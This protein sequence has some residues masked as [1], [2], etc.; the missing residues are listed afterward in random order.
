MFLARFCVFWI[1]NL[2]C[3]L[4][5]YVCYVLV[6]KT[7]NLESPLS[8]DQKKKLTQVVASQFNVWEKKCRFSFKIDKQNIKTQKL[9]NFR[10]LWKQWLSFIQQ[11][12]TMEP[13]YEY[14]DGILRVSQADS[15]RDIYQQLLNR[16]HIEPFIHHGVF[17]RV[18]PGCKLTHKQFDNWIDEL[19][20]DSNLLLYREYGYPSASTLF[21]KKITDKNLDQ[22]VVYEQVG[23]Y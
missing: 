23:E 4:T 8:G 10:M 2:E 6:P 13:L 15:D 11:F 5:D 16:P 12:Q 19:Q 1:R 17:E 18:A 22:G 7:H 9:P 20:Q 14:N 3:L 21:R